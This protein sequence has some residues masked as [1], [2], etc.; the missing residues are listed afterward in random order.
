VSEDRSIVTVQQSLTFMPAM[1]VAQAIARRKAVVALVKSEMWNNE[2]D[3]GAVPG[4]DKPTLRKPGA[5][6]LVTF[7]GLSPKFPIALATVI[8]DW[9]GQEHGGEPLFYY[10]YTCQLWHGAQFVAEADGSCNSRESKYRYRWV[11][12]E[13]VPIGVDRDMLKKRVGSITEFAFAVEK[14]ETSGKYGK[15]AEYWQQFKD[16]IARGTARKVQRETR[17]GS[18]RDAWEIDATVYRIPNDDI[19]SQVNTIQ[20]MAQKR[21]LV[22]ATL[23]A[24]NASEF[25]TQDLEDFIEDNVVDS[26]ARIVTPPPAHGKVAVNAKSP[27]GDEPEFA[28]SAPGTLTARV[29]EVIMTAPVGEQVVTESAPVVQSSAEQHKP[30]AGIDPDD[31]IKSSALDWI[32]SSKL[33]SEFWLFALGKPE[34]GGYGLTKAQVHEACGVDSMTKF[35]GTFNEALALCAEANEA[36]GAKA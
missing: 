9:T 12:P 36:R 8:E 33:T 6:K 31:K 24:V 18:K 4:T 19:A 15:A 17:T 3:A 11:G 16:A 22:G 30:V 28:P 25:F 23:L 34:K 21:A 5:E 20:K 35:Q 14:A 32:E 1:E 27:A 26:T 13:D 2:T 29:K 10:R 7:F